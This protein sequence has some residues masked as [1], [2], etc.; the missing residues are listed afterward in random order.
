MKQGAPDSLG[1]RWSRLRLGGKLL[2]EIKDLSTILQAICDLYRMVRNSVKLSLACIVLGVVNQACAVSSGPRAT[3][4]SIVPTPAI[5]REGAAPSHTEAP[6]PPP[7]AHGAVTPAPVRVAEVSLPPTDVPRVSVTLPPPTPGS[8]S[9]PGSTAQRPPA[10][11]VTVAVPLSGETERRRPAT[12]SAANERGTAEA[13]DARSPAA[14]WN[15]APSAPVRRDTAAPR[16]DLPAAE[17]VRMTTA[18]HVLQPADVLPWPG[19]DSAAA[20]APR[21]PLRAVEPAAAAPR[22]VDPVPAVSRAAEPTPVAAVGEPPAP[23]LVPAALTD[24]TPPA[25][26][27]GS[28]W[29]RILAGYAIPEIDTAAVRRH[30]AWYLNRPDYLARMVERSRR[31]LFFVVEELEKRGMPSDLALLPMIESAYNPGAYSR[32]HAAGMWQFIP[33]TGRRYGLE[34]NWWYDG[35]RDVMAATRAALD[36]LQKL[37]ADFGDWQLALAA[38]NWGEGA[39]SRAMEKNRRRN[40]PTGYLDLKMP[41]ETANYLP[42]LQAVKNIVADPQ[43]YGL[44]LEDIPNQPYFTRVALP[45]HMDVKRAAALAEMEVDEFR[46]LN[47][48]HNRPVI[49]PTGSTSVL[50]PV[51]KA[52][53]FHANFEANDAP[54][55]T[56]QVYTLRPKESLE[57]VASRYGLAPA[58]L[59]QVNG[60]GPR[61][62]LKPGQSLLVPTPSEAKGS[63][64]ERAYSALSR[65]PAFVDAAP[66]HHKVRRGETLQ[67]IA[68]DF[69]LSPAELARW[70]H[71]KGGRVSPGQRIA[72]APPAPK[73]ARA[74]RS[75]KASKQAPG[76]IRVKHSPSRP[77]GGRQQFAARN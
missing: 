54:L 51:D 59:R 65:Q 55:V 22:T 66:R 63:D 58:T 24:D 68:E 44:T 75:G 61:R 48:A 15:G 13:A 18:T 14:A 33:A 77:G 39:V 71:L 38:Y 62:H 72:L 60:I 28:L 32:A 29:T 37:H 6:R 5:A 52:E 12:W 20:V 73:Q 17:P 26:A 70:N 41:A 35:R 42:K 27:T 21:P 47:P 64:I 10:D 2:T 69:G 76:V 50:L 11:V 30:E 74:A 19:L 53:V 34:Q 31:Y 40:K 49:T 43:R 45:A 7:L 25:P 23:E 56:W 46:S 36:Y 67:S 16:R 3:A 8:P 57:T 4:T 1:N 9:Q